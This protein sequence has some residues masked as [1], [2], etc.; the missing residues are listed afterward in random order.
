ME[1]LEAIWDETLKLKNISLG[2]TWTEAHFQQTRDAMKNAKLKIMRLYEVIGTE[3]I[4]SSRKRRGSFNTIGVG[5]KTLFGTMDNDDA[6]YFNEKISTLDL[7][8]HRVYQLEKDQLTIKT[9]L[10]EYIQPHMDYIAVSADEQRYLPMT[11]CDVN[12][13]KGDS[14]KICLGPNVV[15]CLT[16]GQDTC[17]TAYF[18]LIEPTK[19]ICETRLS[20]V[21]TSIWTEIPNTDR[22]IFVLPR[23]EVM[24]F[25]CPGADGLPEHDGTEYVQGTGLLTL[26]TKCEMIESSFRIYSKI[27][28]KSRIELNVSSIIRTPKVQNNST[29]LSDN[30]Y[31]IIAKKLKN[32][33]AHV[34]FVSTSLND[35]KTVSIRLEELDSILN[36]YEPNNNVDYVKHSISIS[37]VLVILIVIIN[38]FKL[39]RFYKM[40][41]KLYLPVTL[42]Q[43][44]ENKEVEVE[45]DEI[46]LEDRIKISRK[47]NRSKN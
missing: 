41:K 6:E 44:E 31:D 17:E 45:L 11:Q 29:K 30:T 25:T 26:P 33:T 8:Q 46:P 10:Y 15:N 37:L 19:D 32:A 22:W 13:C 38:Y 1:H 40:N 28:Y 2:T 21:A 36:K 24:S 7:N 42:R 35:L 47:K 39:C 12:N 4:T 16:Q 34:R 9:Q 5:L 18:R 43:T 3:P 20:Y 23:E 14:V 27:V